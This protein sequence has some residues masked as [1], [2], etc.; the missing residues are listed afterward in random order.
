MIQDSSK[1][2]NLDILQAWFDFKNAHLD[3]ASANCS[4]YSLKS[5]SQ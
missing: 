4:P 1:Y 5:E 3:I 2:I